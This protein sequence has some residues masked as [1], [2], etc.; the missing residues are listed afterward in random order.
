MEAASRLVNTLLPL[1]YAL[2]VV[3]YAADF[4]R[5]DV[6]ARGAARR[7]MELTLGLHAAHLALRTALYDHVPLASLAEV[8]TT[9]AFAVALVYIVV[10]RRSGSPRTGLFVVSLSLAAQTLSSAFLESHVSFPPILRSPLFALHT[11]A[12]VIGYAAF[13]LSAV[14]GV[15]YLLLHH[16]LKRSRFGLVYDRLPPLETLARMSLGAVLVGLA[17]LTVTIACGSLWAASEFPGF[18]RDPK[19]LLTVAVW[20]T[21]GIA[22]GLHW[23]R[24]WSGRRTITMSLIA[25]GLLIFSMLAGKLLFESFHVFA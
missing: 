16:E 23:G 5:E 15:L 11:V 13:A 17:A 1:M 14:Y 3:A 6:F 10:E 24:G 2:T 21:Y 22:L 7:L 20:V 19:F 25:F 18:T 9:V 8:A 4:F 12:A